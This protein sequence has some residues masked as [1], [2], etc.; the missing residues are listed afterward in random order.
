[1][2]SAPHGRPRGLG[3]FL[4]TATVPP[5]LAIGTAIVALLAAVVLCCAVLCRVVLVLCEGRRTV[6]YRAPQ[7]GE[8]AAPV[9][10]PPPARCS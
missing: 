2:A 1:M 3:A 4:A 5:G 7:A 6:L 10:Y 8:E 9:L